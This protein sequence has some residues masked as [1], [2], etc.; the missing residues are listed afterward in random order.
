MIFCTSLMSF[1]VYD[2]S[3]DCFFRDAKDIRITS[4]LFRFGLFVLNNLTLEIRS[5]QYVFS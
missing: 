5:C 4:D 1:W 3:L 2:P